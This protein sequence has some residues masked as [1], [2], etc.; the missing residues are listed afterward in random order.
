MRS[1]INRTLKSYG[2]HQ[3]EISNWA[4]PRKESIHNKYYWNLTEYISV[5]VSSHSLI[6]SKREYNT[7]NISEYIRCIENDDFN[8]IRKDEDTNLKSEYFLMGLRLNKGVSIEKYKMLFNSDPFNDFD[9]DRLIKRKLLIR[10]KD[11]IRLSK[12]GRDIGNYVFID[13]I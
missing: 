8:T 5:G 10:N 12:R 7:S 6:N 13:F 4:K 1:L 11:N 2:Y 9:L 3:Y